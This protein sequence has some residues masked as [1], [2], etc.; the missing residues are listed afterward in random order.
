LEQG[1][2]GEV[3]VNRKD[4]LDPKSLLPRPSR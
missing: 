2:L 3:A 1:Q 4:F